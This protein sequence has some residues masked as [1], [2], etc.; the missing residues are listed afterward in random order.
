VKRHERLHAVQL[1]A[2]RQAEHLFATLLDR[3]FS[4]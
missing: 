3:A 2:L 4:G 1:E